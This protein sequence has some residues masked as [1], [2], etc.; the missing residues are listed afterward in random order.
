MK[1]ITLSVL[2]V[3]SLAAKAA[4]SLVTVGQASYG[5]SGCPAGSVAGRITP[6][7]VIYPF[8]YIADAGQQT[9]KRIDRKSCALTVPI[10][11]AQ[12]YQASLVTVVSGFVSAPAGSQVRLDHE[13]FFAGARGPKLSKIYTGVRNQF[14]LSN[15]APPAALAWSACGAEANVRLNTSVLAQSNARMEETLGGIGEIRLKLVTRRC[16]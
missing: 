16:R 9:G 1:I 7:G 10:R 11:V 12:G 3:L 2:T 6:D 5:G 8:Q 4:P 15:G 13:Q 14:S